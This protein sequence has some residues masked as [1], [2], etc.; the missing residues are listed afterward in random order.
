MTPPR[1]V[2]LFANFR[3]S[4]TVD[5]ISAARS[6]F[7]VA[8]VPLTEIPT[9]SPEDLDQK[10]RVHGRAHDTI[11]IGGGDGTL[12]AAADALLDLKKPLGIL[13]LGTANDLARTLG[14]PPDPAA[15]ARVIAAGHTRQI[16]LGRV[17]DRWFFNAASVGLPVAIAR[18]HDPELK[19]RLKVF[20][21]VVATW[22]ALKGMRRFGVRIEV[23]G[24]K[25]VTRAI[26]VT[27][28]NGVHFGGGM[29]V[30]ADASI[31]DGQLDVFALEARHFLDLVRLAPII[32]FG[33]QQRDR[34][35]LT[36]R[37]REVR[38]ETRRP[39]SVNTDGEITTRTPAVF[40]VMEKAIT[41]HVPAPPRSPFARLGLELPVGRPGFSLHRPTAEK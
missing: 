13:P 6:A 41:V 11:V 10:I 33:L 31:D 23:D 25:V 18:A 35:V 19:R 39:R 24:Q 40:S 22:R 36:F 28:G 17:N 1:R 5:G 9:D 27:V 21:Y 37:G 34:Q 30:R 16:D 38:I 26:Q 12:N 14:L 32:R 8:G 7:E 4:R 3:S 15:A 20:A 29:T 2:V